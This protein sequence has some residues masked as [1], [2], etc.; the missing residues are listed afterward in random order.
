M[1]AGLNSVVGRSIALFAICPMRALHWMSKV[2]SVFPINSPWCCRATKSG[3]AFEALAVPDVRAAK[4]E[5]ERD[6]RDALGYVARLA[7]IDGK[8]R[9]VRC[10]SPFVGKDKFMSDPVEA[11]WPSVSLGPNA[12]VLQFINDDCAA[13]SRSEVPPFR[14]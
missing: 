2:R 3:D 11:S 14:R 13:A 12:D 7:D 5:I 1:P 8:I 6:L 10:F 9:P 4:Q